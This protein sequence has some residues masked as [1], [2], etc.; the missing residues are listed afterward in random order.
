MATLEEF[1]TQVGE[2]VEKEKPLNKNVDGVVS[3][4]DDDE[5]DQ[6]I[7]DRATELYNQQENGWIDERL[8][9]YGSINSQLD[10]IFW[11]IDS[12]KLD[13]T[14]QWYK[15]IKKVKDDIPKPS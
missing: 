2:D 14:G 15:A 4:L 13:K 5:Y 9:A 7:L 12:N 1:K 8:Q 6:L 11:D 3:E 10:K